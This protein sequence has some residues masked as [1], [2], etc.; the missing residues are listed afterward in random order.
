M[1]EKGAP[2]IFLESCCGNER[3]NCS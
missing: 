3:S 2:M 1:A